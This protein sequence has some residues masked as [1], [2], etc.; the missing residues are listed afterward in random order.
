MF[1]V[2]KSVRDFIQEVKKWGWFVKLRKKYKYKKIKK[3]KKIFQENETNNKLIY[4]EFKG[5]KW[6]SYYD[7]DD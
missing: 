4:N 5:E 3:I 2:L 1:F 6:K 7:I